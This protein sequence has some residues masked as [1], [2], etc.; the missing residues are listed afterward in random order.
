MGTL[1]TVLI[2]AALGLL[3]TVSTSLLALVAR[4]ITRRA[5]VYARYEGPVDADIDILNDLVLAV[6]LTGVV[7]VTSLF[8]VQVIF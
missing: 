5:R 6:F 2:A 4:S 7:I 8:L 1:A 3:L